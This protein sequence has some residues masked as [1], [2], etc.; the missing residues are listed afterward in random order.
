MTTTKK[1]ER[2]EMKWIEWNMKNNW[3]SSTEKTD[4]T[5]KICYFYQ[6]RH[7]RERKRAFIK[8][9]VYETGEEKKIY[10]KW[11][12]VKQSTKIH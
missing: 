4:E 9:N 8:I 6:Q 5:K 10:P 12:D 2:N 1:K 11:N 7:L 3:W